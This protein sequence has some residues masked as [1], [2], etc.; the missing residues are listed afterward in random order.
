VLRTWVF[1]ARPVR[2]YVQPEKVPLMVSM[3]GWLYPVF[4][5][6]MGGP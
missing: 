4:G 1:E 6:L 2:F 3:F 5:P